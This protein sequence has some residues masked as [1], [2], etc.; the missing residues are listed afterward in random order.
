M[1][2]GVW[3][4]V[5]LF[6]ICYAVV[7]AKCKVVSNRTS[8]DVRTL[9]IKRKLSSVH[10]RSSFEFDCKYNFVF[11]ICRISVDQSWYLVPWPIEHRWSPLLQISRA[12]FSFRRWPFL[13]VSFLPIW[14]LQLHRTCNC[15]V[16][17]DFSNLSNWLHAI[18]CD[19]CI[20]YRYFWIQHKCI[21]PALRPI[22]RA[23]RILR[24]V[25]R[26]LL[27]RSSTFRGILIERHRL[28]RPLGTLFAYCCCCCYY[29]HDL[30]LFHL[31]SSRTFCWNHSMMICWTI[32]T[33][34]LL[35]MLTLTL[36][37]RPV[38]DI[39]SNF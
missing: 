21:P 38:S 12:I 18:E 8:N 36:C 16:A 29:C 28:W 24:P 23:L 9:C 34:C 26:R 15:Y 32:L 19:S 4:F 11:C 14:P 2:G 31:F 6:A 37:P 10:R 33:H 7:C 25:R 27:M 30:Y 17:M 39:F 3:V 22:H 5:C 13:R 1:G 35:Q 20:A